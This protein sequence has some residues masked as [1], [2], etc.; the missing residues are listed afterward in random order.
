MTVR[1]VNRAGRACLWLEDGFVDLERGS[2]GR[3]PSDPMAA[4]A[5]WSEVIEWAAGLNAGAVEGPLHEEQLGPPVPRPSKVFAIGLN[6]RD[7]AAEAGLP[8]PDVPLV[9]TKFPNCLVGP[10]HAVQL[11]SEYVDWEVEL[12]VVIGRGGRGIKAS[13]AFSHIAGYTVGQDIS[14]RKAQFAGNPPQFSMGKSYDTFGPIGP[15]V[16]PLASFSDPS[17]LRLTCEVNGEMMQDSRTREMIFPVAELVEFLSRRCTLEPGDLIFTGT[18]AGV[19]STRKPRRYLRA[20]DVIRSWV[21]GVGYLVNPCVLEAGEE[22][23]A[24]ANWT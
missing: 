11:S 20:G 13:E 5:R 18:P 22:G 19:G 14:D 8:I 10:R 24:P 15:A 7:H 9:F 2:Q 23:S 17:D 12:V 21:E 3:F 16:V 6:Y 1:F 4:L